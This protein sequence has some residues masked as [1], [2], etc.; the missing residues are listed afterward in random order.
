M[1][2]AFVTS[3]NSTSSAAA[4]DERGSASTA[5]DDERTRPRAIAVIAALLAERL[6][7]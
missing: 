1:P 2:S 7:G 5:H 3:V 4:A 6:A